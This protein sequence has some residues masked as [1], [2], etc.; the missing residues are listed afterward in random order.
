[1]SEGDDWHAS[2]LKTRCGAQRGDCSLPPYLSRARTC[3]LAFS[4]HIPLRLAI[5]AV[6]LYHVL[7]LQFQP[8]CYPSESEDSRTLLDWPVRR[9][10]H[11]T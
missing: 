7:L 9:R 5:A 2:L 4:S 10:Y 6:P 3:A 8:R 11:L 1:M